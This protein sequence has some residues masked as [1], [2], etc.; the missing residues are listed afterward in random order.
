MVVAA[1]AVVPE[2]LPDRPEDL[3]AVVTVS[4]QF[5]ETVVRRFCIKA[6]MVVPVLRQMAVVAVVA[7]AQLDLL[8]DLTLVVQVEP[9]THQLS[10]VHLWCMRLVVAVEA[11]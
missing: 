11:V 8:E 6:T 4:P 1:A 10:P 5:L 7:V 3:E 9:G 2:R